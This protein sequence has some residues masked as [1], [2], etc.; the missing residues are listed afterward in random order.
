VA[1]S[2]V[3]LGGPGTARLGVERAELP[4][5]TL[6][7]TTAPLVFD[8]LTVQGVTGSITWDAHAFGV[9]ETAFR[10]AGFAGGV[11]VAEL[12]VDRADLL[13][14]GRT[15][16]V[17]VHVDRI[18]V[19]ALDVGSE[20][21]RVPGGTLS[22]VE[23]R[24][25]RVRATVHTAQLGQDGT[26]RLEGTEA[27]TRV[28][29]QRQL[30][31]PPVAQDHAP[32]WLGGQFQGTEPYFGVAFPGSPYIPKAIDAPRVLLHLADEGI[33]DPPHTWDLSLDL[34][35][36]PHDAQGHL[37]VSVSGD[38]AGGKLAFE[39]HVE[40]AGTIHADV[41]VRGLVL[42]E[43]GMYLD[44]PMSRFAMEIK[45][46]R[47]G[48]DLRMDLEGSTVSLKGTGSSRSLKMQGSALAGVA[49]TGFGAVS[50]SDN[51]VSIPI[52]IEG[53]LADPDF[54]PFDLLLSSYVGGLHKSAAKSLGKAMKNIGGP[55]EGTERAKQT[56][57]G[58]NVDKAWGALKGA[59][60][61]GTD[62]AVRAGKEEEAKDEAP[63]KLLDTA[64]DTG[65]PAAVDTGKE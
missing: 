23:A 36:G 50:G 18:V 43:L 57:G 22:G 5:G 54:S 17:P 63:K 60:K 62:D 1:A 46:G 49:N 42:G 34:S 11:E 44:K 38:V 8:T 6:T 40:P 29:A 9:P 16:A 10:L 56:G 4:G 31:L 12:R 61:G 35:L 7:P 24:W 26:V 53:D 20:G 13:V 58:R 21:W 59:L 15:G 41:G 37:P 27:W 28:N 48:A 14:H 32:V 25:E 47:G 19:P 3:A 30:D 39:G 52:E 55:E 51:T 65:R 45:Q 2:G 64:V 33:A